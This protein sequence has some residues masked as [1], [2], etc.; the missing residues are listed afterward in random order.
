MYAPQNKN[1]YIT[2]SVL[3]GLYTENICTPRQE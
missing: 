1:T 2:M 3:V